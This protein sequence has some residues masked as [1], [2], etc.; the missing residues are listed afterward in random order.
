M[1]KGFC[2]SPHQPGQG[3]DNNMKGRN[4]IIAPTIKKARGQQK[5]MNDKAKGDKVTKAAVSSAVLQRAPPRGP[6]AAAAAA[7]G[8]AQH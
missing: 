5:R 4:N 8:R 2:R 7:G 3:T 1:G 6:A